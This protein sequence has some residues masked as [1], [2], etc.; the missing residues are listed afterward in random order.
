MQLLAIHWIIFRIKNEIW[1]SCARTASVRR[2]GA[3]KRSRTREDVFGS[4]R[5]H[6]E[7]CSLCVENDFLHEKSNGLKKITERKEVCFIWSDS[8]FASAKR[9]KSLQC[10]AFKVLSLSSKLLNMTF[11]LLCY[12]CNSSNSAEQFRIPLTNWLINWII[13]G[14]SFLE[15]DNESI[16]QTHL[17]FFNLHLAPC[18]SREKGRKSLFWILGI[19]SS[20]RSARAA[21]H[22]T[23]VIGPEIQR[24]DV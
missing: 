17:Y 20:W 9:R 16:L 15:Y 4:C 1:T 6:R 22:P 23:D 8:L 13:L 5:V 3:K 11:V 24:D 10:L 2:R 14:L 21:R 18:R 19:L 7:T 12:P